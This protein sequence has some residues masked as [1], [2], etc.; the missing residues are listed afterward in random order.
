MSD[1]RALES[2]H[3]LALSKEV[4]DHIAACYNV[5]EVLRRIS[6]SPLASELLAYLP[7]RL[8][9]SYESLYP[10]MEELANADEADGQWEQTSFADFCDQYWSA[11][12]LR[13]L[14]R[15][16]PRRA[17]DELKKAICWE[18]RH[19]APSVH[20]VEEF[21]VKI[22]HLVSEKA[23]ENVGESLVYRDVRLHFRTHE[24]IPGLKLLWLL[25]DFPEPWEFS[26]PEPNSRHSVLLTQPQQLIIALTKHFAQK[27]S[28]KRKNRAERAVREHFEPKN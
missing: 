27:R 5:R 10:V 3:D 12:L 13:P 16:D 24:S 9:F 26:R 25:Y 15:R 8:G 2:C 21:I 14:Q 17:W 6:Y 23:A 11:I 7:T 20:R 4:I 19:L 22:A 1:E 18:P 28:K